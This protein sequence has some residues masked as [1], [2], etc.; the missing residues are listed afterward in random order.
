MA[1]KIEFFEVFVSK[2]NESGIKYALTGSI[3]SMLYGEPRMTNDIDIVV[4]IFYK[5]ITNII[6]A[7]SHEV[8]YVPPKVVIEMEIKRDSRGSFNI[9]H[10]KSGLKADIFPVGNN[11]LNQWAILNASEILIG[12]LKIMLAP[13]EYVIIMKLEYY[14]EG[15]SE[16][17]ISDIKGILENSGDN[18]D[19]KILNGMIIEYHLDE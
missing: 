19:F 3:A 8:Y 7:F 1:E 6:K 15:G 10:K 18:I 4:E 17:H 13:V 2:L 5:D 12:D 16:K 14:K 9:I 11:K